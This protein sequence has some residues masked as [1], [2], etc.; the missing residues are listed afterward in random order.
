MTS[1]TPIATEEWK[2]RHKFQKFSRVSGED[3]VLLDIG[4]LCF[5]EIGAMD[6]KQRDH[7]FNIR[8]P[9]DWETVI[10]KA[11]QSVY[12]SKT[13]LTCLHYNQ[14]QCASQGLQ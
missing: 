2:G 12:R 10:P 5:E 11:E 14:G 9:S 3:H 8:N 13:P 1:K 4:I 7:S 6:G